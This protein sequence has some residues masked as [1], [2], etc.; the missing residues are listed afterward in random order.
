MLLIAHKY[1]WEVII[2]FRCNNIR[3][4][5]KQTELLYHLRGF[6][7]SF[8]FLPVLMLVKTSKLDLYLATLVYYGALP[9]ADRE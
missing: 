7:A 1:G 4:K 3:E 2:H 5:E 6:V 9:R 8:F